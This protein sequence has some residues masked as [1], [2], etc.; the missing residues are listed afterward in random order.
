MRHIHYHSTG[1]P[2]VPEGMSMA[3][4]EEEKS[5]SNFLEYS[6]PFRENLWKQIE[7]EI[8][9]WHVTNYGTDIA[10]EL[11]RSAGLDDYMDLNF[12]SAIK[13]SSPEV[14]LRN[15]DEEE[16]QEKIHFMNELSKRALKAKAVEIDL[17]II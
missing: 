3:E 5:Q 16:K 4:W 12:T 15:L 8:D 11:I 14:L 10:A 2:N 7:K 17:P 1:L 13:P 6:S 9:L